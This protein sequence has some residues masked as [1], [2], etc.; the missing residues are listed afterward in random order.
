MFS[1]LRISQSFTLQ[2]AFHF[3]RKGHRGLYAVS[4][5][6]VTRRAAGRESISVSPLPPSKFTVVPQGQAE[7]VIYLWKPSQPLAVAGPRKGVSELE[8]WQVRWSR[9]RLCGL[10]LIMALVAL[11]SHVKSFSC[12][13]VYLSPPLSVHSSTYTW[14]PLLLPL[15]EVANG[16]V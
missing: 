2:S 10:V 8:L 9:F 4:H 3:K 14:Q 6:V 5:P 1:R 11:T 12:A 13:W 7:S 15:I 16:E